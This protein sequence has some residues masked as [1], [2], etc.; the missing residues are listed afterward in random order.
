MV[1]LFRQKYHADDAANIGGQ[2]DKNSEESSNDDEF[3]NNPYIYMFYTPRRDNQ[4]A[5]HTPDC[6]D[7][8]VYHFKK[9]K[10]L[11]AFRLF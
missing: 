2:V 4:D 5:V 6:D 7:F 11:K 9:T 8:V 3:R 10:F 1:T